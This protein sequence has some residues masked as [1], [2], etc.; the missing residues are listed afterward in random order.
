MF[1]DS[2][3]N[4]MMIY[5]VQMVLI[6]ILVNNNFM[7]N[8][9]VFQPK[10]QELF[11]IFIGI[12]IFILNVFSIFV[13]RD[14]YAKNKEER[15]FLINSIRFKYIEEQNRIYRQNHHDI[16]N[17]LIVISELVK[18][19]RYSEL[20]NYLS[21]YIEEIDKNLVTINT[22]VNEIDILLYSKI[23][24]AKSKGIEVYFKCDTQIQCHK[25]HVLN[26]VSVLG[27]L[28]DNAI[29]AC[30]EMEK[31]KYIAIDIKEDPIDYI[32]HIKNRYDFQK[33]VEPSIFFEEGFST[34]EGRGRGE[35]L[36]IVRNIV[37]KYRGEIKVKTQGGYFDVIVEIPKFSLEGD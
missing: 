2:Y 3:K 5:V 25:K 30:D 33:D 37:E 7:K 10:N 11:R 15:Q 31:D 28:I 19:K 18:E 23:N 6:V 14:L 16:K 13:L 17:H 36:Y 9:D 34:K 12:L 4:A 8:L 29:E 1:K 20:E 21:S 24:N 22:A 35:G 32:F 26:L 27:N